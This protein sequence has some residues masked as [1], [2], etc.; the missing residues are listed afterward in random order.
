MSNLITQPVLAAI[1][2]GLFVAPQFFLPIV[3]SLPKAVW[4]T[5]ALIPLIGSHDP[6]SYLLNLPIA[7]LV[8]T[9]SVSIEYIKFYIPL[10]ALTASSI[11]LMPLAMLSAM[12]M[13][14]LM[15]QP[16]Y[17]A[18]EAKVE[19]IPSKAHVSKPNHG[20]LQSAFAL[21]MPQNIS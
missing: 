6:K 17:H 21:V 13:N 12:A 2:L 8:I 4:L 14:K 5:A 3:G 7:L 1:T 11:L 15:I 10:L 16:A 19:T 20:I 18:Y 9:L